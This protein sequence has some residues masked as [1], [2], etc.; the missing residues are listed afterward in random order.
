MYNVRDPKYFDAK[1]LAHYLAKELREKDF[2]IKFEAP[3]KETAIGAMTEEGSARGG[4]IMITGNPAKIAGKLP[5]GWSYD[6]ASN[7]IKNGNKAESELFQVEPIN[8]KKPIKEFVDMSD[9]M[10]A[11][12]VARP[13]LKVTALDST[14]F[15]IDLNGRSPDEIDWKKIGGS[16]LEYDKATG[17][18]NV[19]TAMGQ[20]LSFN[21]MTENAKTEKKDE[22][23]E[24]TYTSNADGIME[25]GFSEGNRKTIEN[26]ADGLLTGLSV[27]G[28]NPAALIMKADIHELS[29]SD[30]RHLWETCN[31]VPNPASNGLGVDLAVQD[32]HTGAVIT[33]P[34]IVSQLA[35][36]YTLVSANERALSPERN[37]LINVVTRGGI[38]WDRFDAMYASFAEN[39]DMLGGAVASMSEGLEK[40]ERTD[41]IREEVSSS[42]GPASPTKVMTDATAE[43]SSPEYTDDMFRANNQALHSGNIDDMERPPSYAQIYDLFMRYEGAA[44]KDGGGVYNDQ[45]DQKVEGREAFHLSVWLSVKK[46]L[47]LTCGNDEQRKQAEWNAIASQKNWKFVVRNIVDRVHAMEHQ[48]HEHE[49]EGMER[50][51]HTHTDDDGHRH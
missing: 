47:D 18:V 46:Y 1:H 31:L 21:V 38:N 44:C 29:P 6:P 19:E 24:A 43:A 37:P 40:G 34:K 7:T 32:R 23:R 27:L 10:Y 33:D 51:R 26:T 42:L 9:V 8:K 22:V 14:T 41:V 12:R 15:G 11:I 4:K 39:P 2:K 13:D 49:D 17:T 30:A 20:R 50:T 48:G 45:T 5:D 16:N 25:N 3:K 28:A 35:I 36:M